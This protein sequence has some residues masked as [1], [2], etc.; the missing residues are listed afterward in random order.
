MAPRSAK[1]A[2]GRQKDYSPT[3]W[4]AFFEDFVDVK[5]SADEPETSFR[6]Y[7][8]KPAETP[9]APVLVLLHGGGFN[10][11]TW[12]VFTVSSDM[13]STDPVKKSANFLLDR[14]H[15]DYSLPMP[16]D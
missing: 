5:V 14:N 16:G 2:P 8:S 3:E 9:N 10:G 1:S 12:S 11:L 6:V 4:K 7:R 15:F 13:D